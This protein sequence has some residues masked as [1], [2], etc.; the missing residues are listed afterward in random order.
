MNK[1]TMKKMAKSRTAG[2]KAAKTAKPLVNSGTGKRSK[3]ND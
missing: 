1:R 2:W 3:T